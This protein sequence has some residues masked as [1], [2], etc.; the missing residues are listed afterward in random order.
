MTWLEKTKTG[1]EV[2]GFWENKKNS[3]TSLSADRQARRPL[4][5]LW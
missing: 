4:L 3:V 1:Q 5:T 2:L